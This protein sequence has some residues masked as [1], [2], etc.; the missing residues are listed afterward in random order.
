MD[1]CQIKSISE[2]L[3]VASLEDKIASVSFPLCEISYF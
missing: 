1:K 3:N 2:K